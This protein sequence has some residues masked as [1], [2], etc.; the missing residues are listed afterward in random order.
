MMKELGRRKFQELPQVVS[1]FSLVWETNLLRLS[2]LWLGRWI[3]K[4]GRTFNSERN[5]RRRLL[6]MC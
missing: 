1:I 6:E 5:G 3:M 2:G 4:E